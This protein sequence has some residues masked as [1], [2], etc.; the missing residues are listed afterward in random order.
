MPKTKLILVEKNSNNS[1]GIILIE[2]FYV[3]VII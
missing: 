1:N 2:Y 3:P